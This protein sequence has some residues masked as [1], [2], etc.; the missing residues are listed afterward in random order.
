[1]GFRKGRKFYDQFIMTPVLAG[2]LA[3]GD[4]LLEDCGFI[5]F[6]VHGGHMKDVIKNQ[7]SSR[8]YGLDKYLIEA[9][10]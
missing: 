1:M 7:K 4:K 9:G 8:K 5:A 2:E 6:G 3:D 10:K